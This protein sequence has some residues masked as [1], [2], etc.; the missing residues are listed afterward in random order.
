MMIKRILR[1]ILWST[2]AILLVAIPAIMTADKTRI[3]YETMQQDYRLLE[4]ANTRLRQ[5]VEDLQ[6]YVE[7]FRDNK[8]FQEKVIR[9]ELG[10]IGQNELV[11]R[12]VWPEN[13]DSAGA[14]PKYPGDRAASGVGLDAAGGAGGLKAMGS[15]SAAHKNRAGRD[16]R[17]VD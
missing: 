10:F 16:H 3:K 1:A 11:Y 12:I 7:Y 17:G 14:L 13:E 9:Q 15:E 4:E 5:E 8:D 6:R 2:V